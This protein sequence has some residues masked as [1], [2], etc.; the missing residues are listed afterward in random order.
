MTIGDIRNYIKD[1]FKDLVFE[2]EDHL[3]FVNGKPIQISVSGKIKKYYE[4]FDAIGVSQFTYM[5][6]G[7][8]SPQEQR[9]DW[10]AIAD[11]AIEIGNKTHLFGEL[12][13]F[14]RNLRPQSQYDVAVMKFWNDLPSYV[15]PVMVEVKMYH[16]TS[17]YA[18]TSDILLFNTRTEKFIIADYKT[19]KDL[20]KNYN[21]KTM[22]G[23]FSHLLDTPF[24]HYEIQLSYY[25]ILIEQIG[26]EVSHR[27]IVHLKPDGNYDIYDT[28]D[29]TQVLKYD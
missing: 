7:Y 10:K 17:L 21:G 5:H 25:Q 26:L 2:P 27:K 12:Y 13:A 15:I 8:S 4:P 11:E 9:D 19:N 24:S 6:K 20:F 22:L 1:Q 18:G 23:P 28:N 3:Y 29:Y 14:N 16:R